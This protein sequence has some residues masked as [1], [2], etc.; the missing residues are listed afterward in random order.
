MEFFIKETDCPKPYSIYWKI[1]NVG[2]EAEKR[3]CIRGQIIF[4]NSSTQQE[5]TDFQGEHYAE[6]YLV[7]NKVCVAKAHI[8]VPIGTL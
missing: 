4:T 7:K 8:D 5:H 6:C 2:P 1:R 3:N